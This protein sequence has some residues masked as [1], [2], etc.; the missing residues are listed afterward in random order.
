MNEPPECPADLP[1]QVAAHFRDLA[2]LLA[3]RVRPED[4]YLLALFANSWQTWTEAQA[5]VAAQGS[6]VMSGGTAIQHPSLAVAAQAHAQLVQLAKELGLSPA[7]RK[8]LP[9]DSR[10]AAEPPPYRI[11]LFDPEPPPPPAAKKPAARRKKQNAKRK[12]A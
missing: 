6:I 12:R 1:D 4:R 3:A 2:E 5:R 11:Q 7:A 9:L 10:D 8:R